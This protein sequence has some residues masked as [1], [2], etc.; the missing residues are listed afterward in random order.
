MLNF[1]VEAIGFK[2]RNSN[3]TKAAFYPEQAVI[4][5]PQL[6]LDAN[7]KKPSFRLSKMAS[8]L[9]G[10]DLAAA[11]Q[12]VLFPTED[13]G[14]SII[15]VTGLGIDSAKTY[16]VWQNGCF[17]SKP[18]LKKINIKF[19]FINTRD[20]EQVFAL[21][22]ITDSNRPDLKAAKLV[23]L[24]E[25]TEEVVITDEVN[26]VV[27]ESVTTIETEEVAVEEV[28]T[29]ADVNEVEETVTETEDIW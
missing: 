13:G 25:T 21:E 17:S 8:D 23:P 26:E 1:S 2:S 27:E 18:T 5:I 10:I 6:D 29:L 11:N 22:V 3:P 20:G 7:N 14:L 28:E 12:V 19:D 9:L 4:Q 15:N 24:T 16:T